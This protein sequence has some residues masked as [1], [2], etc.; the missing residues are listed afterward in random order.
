MLLLHLG[1]GVVTEGVV[2]QLHSETLRGLY[3]RDL[4]NRKNNGTL[5]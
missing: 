5:S 4:P 2:D 3:E 1:D